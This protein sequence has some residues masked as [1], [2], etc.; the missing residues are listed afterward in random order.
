M[1]TMKTM[2]TPKLFCNKRKKMK[3][4]YG[5]PEKYIDVTTLCPIVDDSI[6]IP[7][8]EDIRIQRFGDPL[9]NVLKH[10]LI[11]KNNGTF[12]IYHHDQ[13]VRLDCKRNIPFVIIAYNN[14]VFV[15]NFIQQIIK[16]ADSII[17]LDNASTYPKLHE[18]YD[19]LEYVLKG[20]ITIHR[21]N[22][23]YGPH[24]YFKRKDLLPDIFILSDPDLELNPDMPKDFVNRLLQLSLQYK[25]YKVGLAL[26]ISDKAEW[27]EGEY[28]DWS[29][30]NELFFWS[31]PM[32]HPEYE[33]Y[34]APVDTTFCFVNFN[35][36]NEV[37]PLMYRVAG[38]FTCK[39]LP[40]Y[41][42]YAKNNI[43]IIE[44]MHYMKNNCGSTILR[45]IKDDKKKEYDFEKK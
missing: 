5:T 8:G 25:A 12:E 9:P 19:F 23:N 24:V 26:K 27:L 37:Y 4:Y 31:R 32:K 36:F 21:F 44:N 6:V 45:Y 10:I 42:D 16:Y 41:K 18:Y 38:N 30:N 1:K 11:Q 13:E 43:P 28:A 40:W 15:S 17:I 39:H 22:H 34:D 33:F 2:K 29:Y 7:C 20:K 35:Y 14:L 3:I